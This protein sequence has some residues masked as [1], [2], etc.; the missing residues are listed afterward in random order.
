MECGDIEK[1]ERLY[2]NYSKLLFKIALSV[3]NDRHLAE[4]AVQQTFEK[5][6]K[7]ADKIEEENTRATGGLLILMCK[8]AVSEQYRAKKK[9]MGEQIVDEEGFDVVSHDDLWEAL[10][11]RQS[12]ERIKDSL[13]WLKPKY[14]EP[15]ILKYV[16]EL[17]VETIAALL[18]L[19]V[20]TVYTRLARGRAMIKRRI[21]EQ[22]GELE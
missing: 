9:S 7:I 11:Q 22:G 5:V 17:E 8:Q 12:E 3:T 21:I 6:I 2:H 13:K 14:L 16:Y 19:N 18:G 15:I 10:L 1:V 4:D 20:N